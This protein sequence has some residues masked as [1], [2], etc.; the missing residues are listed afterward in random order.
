MIW[1]IPPPV[2]RCSASGSRT[3]GNAKPRDAEKDLMWPR[4]A[5]SGQGYCNFLS[6]DDDNRQEK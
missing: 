1:P 6:N 5:G 2:N 4:L 3:L